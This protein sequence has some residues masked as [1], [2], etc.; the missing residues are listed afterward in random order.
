MFELLPNISY[1]VS[2]PTFSFNFSNLFFF[3]Q[4]DRAHFSRSATAACSSATPIPPT[5]TLTTL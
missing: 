5:L 3:S 4:N 2:M 1:I